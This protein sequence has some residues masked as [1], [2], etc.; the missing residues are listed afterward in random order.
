MA[1]LIHVC[2]LAAKAF[3]GFK[4]RISKVQFEMQP[5]FIRNPNWIS[6]R[7]LKSDQ[8]VTA[9]KQFIQSLLF[10]AFGY[11]YGFGNLLAYVV[12]P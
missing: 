3:L 6:R 12:K 11:K 1:T 9:R 2:S 5:V 8:T 10:G 4:A 7:Y